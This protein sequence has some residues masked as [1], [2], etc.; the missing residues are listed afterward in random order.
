MSKVI[1]ITGADFSD[2][3]IKSTVPVLVDFWA[4]WCGPC[5]AM[6]PILDELSVDLHDKAKIVKVDV[7][8]PDNQSLARE[9]EIMSIPNMKLFKGGEVV[10]DF[11]GMKSK[12]VLQE[13]IESFLG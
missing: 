9:Y 12:E 6:A 13:E 1:N 3:V 8:N 11:V 10:R 5:R 7:E 2:I 4:L